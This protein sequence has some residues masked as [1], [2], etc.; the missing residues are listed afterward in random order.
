L[1]SKEAVVVGDGVVVEG[2]TRKAEK[3]S[4]FIFY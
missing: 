3:E 2:A 4:T 1:D